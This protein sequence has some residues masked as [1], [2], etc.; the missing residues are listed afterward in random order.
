MHLLV[1][2]MFTPFLD[3]LTIWHGYEADLYMGNIDI[4][5]VLKSIA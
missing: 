5:S 3:K 2:Q 1:M 4:Y